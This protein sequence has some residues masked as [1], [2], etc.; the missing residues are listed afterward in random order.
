MCAISESRASVPTIQRIEEALHLFHILYKQTVD[1]LQKSG[2]FYDYDYYIVHAK[3]YNQ[4]WNYAI[5]ITIKVHSVN[6]NIA[7][8]AHSG[9]FQ[10][11]IKQAVMLLSYYIII[12]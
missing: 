5:N 10:N 1:Y 6:S 11:S 2:N 4:K 7:L 3:V 8:L 12:I 9:R